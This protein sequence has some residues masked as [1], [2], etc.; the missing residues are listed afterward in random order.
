M[1]PA[2]AFQSR[3]AFSLLELLVVMVVIGILLGLLLPTLDKAKDH[4]HLASCGSNLHQIGIALATYCNENNGVLPSG[5]VTPSTIDPTRPCNTIGSANVWLAA[6]HTY[7]G[8][9]NML[10]TSLT[11]ARV[12]ICPADA[13]PEAKHNFMTALGSSGMDAYSSYIYRQSD[14]TNSNHLLQPGVN[15]LGQPARALML[16]WQCDGPVPFAHASHDHGEYLN[17]LYSD[18]HVQEFSDPSS[19]GADATAFSAMPGS[20]LKR[21]DQIWVTA[22]YAENGNPDN[23]PQLP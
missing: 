18:G 13:D 1:A 12:L 23:A 2:S 21:L 7:N 14:Q 16:D 15:G 8:L 6:S 5:P 9:G 17:V 22:D 19:F 4:S 3:R 11:D 20:Y 10:A